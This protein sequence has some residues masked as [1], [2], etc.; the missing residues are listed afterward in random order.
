MHVAQKGLFGEPPPVWI[1]F[2]RTGCHL[3]FEPSDKKAWLTDIEIFAAYDQDVEF[4]AEDSPF[5][6]RMPFSTYRSFLQLA[7]KGQM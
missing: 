6:K 5:S 3:E 2:D 7:A 4:G 1:R